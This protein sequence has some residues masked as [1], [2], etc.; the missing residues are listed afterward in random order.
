MPENAT[1]ALFFPT[2]TD[3]SGDSVA[4]AASNF[5]SMAVAAG[6]GSNTDWNN[7]GI[8]SV[9]NLV[10]CMVANDCLVEPLATNFISCCVF[11]LFNEP[12]CKDELNQALENVNISGVV[13]CVQPYI[14]DGA[15]EG[16]TSGLTSGLNLTLPNPLDS[17]TEES[18][19]NMS[20]DSEMD[21]VLCLL[22]VLMPPGTFDSLV[23]SVTDV[24]GIALDVVPIV[25]DIVE[26]GLS[27]PGELILSIFSWAEWQPEV[28]LVAPYKWW[29]CM[30]A[31][32]MFLVGME[33]L[34]L[35]ALQFVV[36]TKR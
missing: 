29:Y 30:F 20:S 9:G 6:P 22:R 12:P 10:D 15:V 19:G 17:L 16:V 8:V 18:V 21:M 13:D 26:N 33:I 27:I 35:L 5:L 25:I 3:L 1:N 7:S 23:Q 14:I 4:N 24:L 28:G 2:G 32:A 11:D 36:W 31:V 34:K